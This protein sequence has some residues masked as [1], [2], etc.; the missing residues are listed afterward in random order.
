[1]VNAT[2]KVWHDDEGWGV[3]ASPD[4][5]GELF[6]HFSNIEAPPDRYRDLRAGEAVEIEW[7]PYPGGQDGYFYRVTRVVRLTHA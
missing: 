4:V 7:E 1:M 2:C 6:A 3:L 5:P